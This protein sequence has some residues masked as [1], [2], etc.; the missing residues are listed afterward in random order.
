MLN[1]SLSKVFCQPDQIRFKHL[2]TE[3]GLSHSW[4]KSICQDSLGFMWFGTNDGLNKYDGYNFTVYKHILNN[5]KSILDNSIGAIYEDKNGNLWIGTDFG[6]NLYDRN[7]DQFIHRNTWPKVRITSFL[8]LEDGRILMGTGHGLF[9]Y[10]PKNDSFISFIH[11][12]TEENTHT[13]S[14]NTVN[15]IITDNNGIIWIGTFDGLNL[16]D[17]EKHQFT[18]FRKKDRGNSVSD[19]TIVAMCLDSKGR[20]WIGTDKGLDLLT[21]E[22]EHPENCNFI[23]Y[24][25]DPENQFSITNGAV[26]ALKEDKHGNLW[27]GT[28]NGGLDIIDLNNFHENNAIF[29][30][31]KYADNDFSLSNNSV[32]SL[33][34]DQNGSVWIGTFG[35]G[36]NMYNRLSEK[37]IHHKHYPN[38][39]N[40][41]NDNSV[42]TIFEDGN[43][44]WIGTE[45]GLNQ[46]DKENKT[47][48][49]FIH[50]PNN[51]K[52]IGS[53]AVLAIEKDSRGNLWIGTWAG[54][55]NLFNR[56]TNTF[57]RFNHDPDD[58][59]SI[60]SDN[61]FDIMEDHNGELWIA[62]MGGGLNVFDYTNKTFK[63]YIASS[64]DDHSV[65][66]DWIR[67]VYENSYG[68]IWLSASKT[69]E[70]F[71]RKKEKFIHFIHDSS[72]Q[73]S[74][75][76][77]GASIFFE[78]SKRNLW[79]GNNGGLNVFNR[80]DSTF[81]YYLQEDGLPND[82]INGILEDDHGNLWLS[83]NKG[84]S[85]FVN[86]INRREKPV[87]K[88]YEISDGLQGNQ[89]RP[90]S[91]YKGTDGKMYFGGTNGF[92]VFH[93]D[94]IK[95][96]P[97]KPPVR[98]THFHL[99][100]KDVPIGTEDSPLKKDISVTKEI[101]LS[102]KQSVITL[103]YAALNFLTPEKNQYAYRLLGFEEE[104]NFVGNKRS[105]TYTNLDPGKYVFQ[106]KAAN[107]DG[108]W[109]DVPASI[110]IIVVPPWWLTWWFRISAIVFI[111]TLFV[112]FYLY[113]MHGIKK[114]N[115]ELEIAV[116]KRTKEVREK[117]LK[118]IDQTTE[119]NETNTLLEERQQLIENQAEELLIQKEKIQEAYEKVTELNNM[120]DKF[121]SIIGHDLKNPIN[122]IMGFSELLKSKIDHI[123]KDRRNKYISA[124]EES[125]KTT[126]ALLENL[127]DWARSQSGR[128]KFTPVN[129]K[130]VQLVNNVLILLKE[131]YSEKNI[132]IDIEIAD[133]CMVYGDN[134]MIET[135]LRNLISNAIKFTHKGGNIKIKADENA[136]ENVITISV[137]DTGVGI[138]REKIEG[139]FRID[140]SLSTYGTTGESGTGLGLILCSEFISRNGGK[141]WVDSKVN[142]GSTFYFTLPV[143]LQKQQDT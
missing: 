128:Y 9:L 70:L 135:V 127:L 81:S 46:F 118:L 76:Y 121:F 35:N 53:N 33:Y 41:I 99:F 133:E 29:H 116:K 39:P 100:N 47:Y 143:A 67:T 71:D 73:N 129:L 49:H 2:T 31:Y 38:N 131:Q 7:N 58:S 111:I 132:S 120:K 123:D 139:L 54:G 50:D 108:L 107:N 37:F 124:I 43:Y 52:S 63:R 23:N 60:G 13:I 17:I 137:S 55:L 93:P 80:E 98:V 51:S 14:H 78:D 25:H 141:I 20:I 117:N 61:I 64:T 85:K 95:E 74:I 34:E 1:T 89:F 77:D 83:T 40:S 32:Y 138:P 6:L 106:V 119:L 45:G 125:S 30:H 59:T 88:N 69:V 18:H 114:R 140:S 75:G 5:N 26:L 87:F 130:V 19:N 101:T 15:T 91:N 115:Q 16:L 3:D 68:E 27:I 113:R 110:K 48:K 36:I 97:Y 44:L 56:K 65:F 109:N 79:I 42:N 136:V 84:I 24:L 82:Q 103:E 12:E 134:N 57:T 28:E 142:E 62:T 104:W 112:V 8:E 66:D 102:Y 22:K 96:N 10:T 90:R 72:D 126:Y 21:Y 94:S 86:G 4:V 105:A 92:N 122:T 11:D